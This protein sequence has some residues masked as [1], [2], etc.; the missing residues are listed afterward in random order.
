MRTKWL[1]AALI[2][3]CLGSLAPVHAQYLPTASGQPASEPIPYRISGA[4]AAPP[5]PPGGMGMGGAPMPGAA[6]LSL[7]SY[8]RNASDPPY[9]PD[10][11]FYTY[12]GALGLQRKRMGHG[13]IAVQDPNNVDSGIPPAPRPILPVEQTFNYVN[14]S[15]TWGVAATIGCYFEGSA[16]EFS[17]FFLPESRS[18]YETLDPG[19]IDVL[20]FNPP[21]GFQGNNGLWLQADRLR[22]T[23]LTQLA[24]GEANFRLW[25]DDNEMLVTWPELIIGLRYFD[26]QETLE[27]FTD[28]EG[29]SFVDRNG[30]PDPRRQATYSVRAHNRLIAP[31]LGFLWRHDLFMC[32]N[33]YFGVKGAWGVNFSEVDVKL[34]RG[35]GLIGFDT[36]RSHTMFSQL[37]E[38]GVG[39]EFRPWECV[40]IRGGYSMLWLLQAPEAVGQV[41][42]DLTATKGRRKDNGNTFYGGPLVDLQLQFVF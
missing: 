35:D 15:L 21:V 8:I 31:Q 11:G 10:H 18:L 26:S 32:L 5:A 22:T 30:N 7:P 1:A 17:G 20:F 38:I 23:L 14:P 33:C 25:M 2:L 40:R 19:R 4:P 13:V 34:Q 6:D 28:D 42:F 16:L 12:I 36:S 39:L 27:I 41:N 3:G 24:N 29:A 9:A 37:Y